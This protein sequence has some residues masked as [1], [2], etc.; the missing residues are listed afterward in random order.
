MGGGGGGEDSA[1]G[2]SRVKFVWVVL[3]PSVKEFF[4]AIYKKKAK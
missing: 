2:L 1:P 3:H 4:K